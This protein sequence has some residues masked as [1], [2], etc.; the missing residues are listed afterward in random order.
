MWCW[1]CGSEYRAGFG[2][3]PDCDAALVD[4]PPQAPSAPAAQHKRT[5]YDL[6]RWSRNQ[7]DA[8][9]FWL[10]RME[11]PAEWR[12]DGVLVVPSAREIQV[13][14]LL[15]SLEEEDGGSDAQ[16]ASV[17]ADTPV[18]TEDAQLAGPGRRF[19]GFLIDYVVV[20]ATSVFL[21]FVSGQRSTGY[22]LSVAV[23]AAYFIGGTAIWGR[24]V[25]KLVLRTVV[26]R[27][28]GVEPPGL[29]VA[30]IRWAIV[31]FGI[32]LGYVAG[33]GGLLSLGWTVAVFIPIFLPARR[34]IHDRGAGTEVLY[35][36]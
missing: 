25:G 28:D 24:T 23:D 33:I 1:T 16:P 22:A 9:T 35:R 2:R 26:V 15:N 12:P 30:T 27:T 36:P 31:S 7:R 5:E 21:Y 8:A 34:G 18:R 32:P 19:A 20:T 6:A 10:E 14:D 29:R 3:C 4:A 11:I 17:R 13:D